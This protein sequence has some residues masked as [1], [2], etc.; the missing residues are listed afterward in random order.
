MLLALAV[1]QAVTA[2]WQRRLGVGSAILVGLG[3]VIAGSRGVETVPLWLAAG[4]ITGL[5]LL[6]VWAMVLRHQPALVPLVT[7]AGAVLAAIHDVVVNA[8]PGAA[9]GSVI[10]AALVASAAVWWYRRLATDHGVT[11]DAALL[12]T[13][14]QP[15]EV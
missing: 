7:A 13:P 11:D 8:F 5:V 15:I 6:A 1:V 9:A 3:F 12:D 14:A 2:G 10:G 4:A